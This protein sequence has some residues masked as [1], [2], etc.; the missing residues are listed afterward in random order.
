MEVANLPNNQLSNWS[1]GVVPILEYGINAMFARQINTN[2]ILR[3]DK[4]ATISYNSLS[5]LNSAYLLYLNR[6]ICGKVKL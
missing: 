5:N 6:Y 3:S 4:H 1:I 2:W